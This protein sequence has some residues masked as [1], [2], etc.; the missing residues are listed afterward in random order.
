MEIRYK[1]YLVRNAVSLDASLLAKWWNDGLIME[2]AGFPL[3]LGISEKEI[4][5]S[6]AKDNDLKR[7]LIIE[8]D[9]IPVGEMNYESKDLTKAEIGIKICDSDYQNKGH[10]KVLLSMLIEELFNIGYDKIV[11]DTNP[12]NLRARHTYEQLGFKQVGIR[13]DSWIDQLGNKQSAVDYELNKND[14][15]NYK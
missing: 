3:G 14:F 4:I 10:G 1:N 2:H 15:N 7:R 9:N 8:I 5:E 11:L 13:V 6:L 12:N